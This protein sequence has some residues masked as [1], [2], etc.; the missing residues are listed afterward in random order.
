MW[1]FIEFNFFFLI[2]CN[3][4]EEMFFK[5]KERVIVFRFKDLVGGVAREMFGVERQGL[6]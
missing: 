2:Q 1:Q 5:S 3:S 6:Y 4:G